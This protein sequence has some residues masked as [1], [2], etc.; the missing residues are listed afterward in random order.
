MPRSPS[1]AFPRIDFPLPN[2]ATEDK[3]KPYLEIPSLRYLQPLSFKNQLRSILLWISLLTAYSM[4]ES[5]AG[6]SRFVSD[7]TLLSCRLHLVD[8]RYFDTYDIHLMYISDYL[9]RCFSSTDHS[10]NK[11][12]YQYPSFPF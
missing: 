9:P 2:V 10:K 1:L 3:N 11:L 4:H 8:G 5:D 12:L 7:A 6:V